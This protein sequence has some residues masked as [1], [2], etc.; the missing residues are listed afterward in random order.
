M[1]KVIIVDDEK[2]IVEGL[3]ETIP[4]ESLNCKV[5]KTAND[6]VQGLEM[7]KTY[8]P[9]I[10]F[11]DV[12]MPNKDGLS[13]I[14]EIK[15]ISPNTQIIVMS[16]FRK[17][18]YVQE[19]LNLGVIK[20]IVKPASLEDI[21]DAINLATSRLKDK[22]DV[23]TNDDIYQIDEN[24]NHLVDQIITYIKTNYAE[25]LTLS[26]VA[27]YF[28]ISNWHLCRILKKETGKNFIEILN[29]IR[30][31]KAKEFL[32]DTN[33]KVYEI[34]RQVGYRELTYFSNMFKKQTGLTPN[35]YRNSIETEK[36]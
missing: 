7:V 8:K 36:R 19:A 31:Q 34:A 14:K 26:F 22:D 29:Q 21:E 15:E 5:I 20:F 2:I 24:Y 25:K 3:V 16:G 30:I 13:M 23:E 17:F 18:E 1:Y 6:G 9:D 11:T 33:L 32:K 28:Y 4:W 10:L 27:E 12:K 35:E